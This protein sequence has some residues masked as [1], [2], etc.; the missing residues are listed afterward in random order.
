MNAT[1]ESLCVGP[2]R[3]AVLA[4]EVVER[5]AAECGELIQVVGHAELR[6][7]DSGGVNPASA[8]FGVALSNLAVMMGRSWAPCSTL[9]TRK[10]L[11]GFP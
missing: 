6:P 1:P 10:N 5:W 11:A 7:T 3:F 4:F 2:Q 9:R 8:M